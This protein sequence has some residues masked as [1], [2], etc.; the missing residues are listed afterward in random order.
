MPFIAIDPAT[1][2]TIAEYP[3]LDRAAAMR[4]V[5]E[6]DAAFRA[7][8]ATDF[9][10]RAVPMRHA[11]RLLRERAN[12]LAELMAREMGK[13][14]GDGRAEVEKCAW[15]CEYYADNAAAFLQDEPAPTDATDSYVTYRPLGPVL[16]VMPWNFPLWQVFRFVAP[17]LMAG[18]AGLLKHAP[19]VPGC[20]LAI[21][22]L[23]RDAGFPEHLFRN[24]FIENDLVGEVIDDPRVRAVT[25]TGSTRAGR[26]VAARAG[27]A[28]K[29]TVL[30]LGGSDPYI[31]LADADLELA[32]TTCVTSRMINGGQSCIS[33]KRFIVARSVAE[34]FKRLVVTAMEAL[35]TGDPFDEATDYGPMARI[36]LRDEL[37]RQVEASVAAGARVLTGAA[38][39]RTPGAFYPPTV[40]ADVA[41][42][43]PAYH[44]ELFGPVAAIITAEDETDALR[45][46]NDSD[47]GLGAAVFTADAARGEDLAARHLE[48]G[49]CFVNS[50]VK[51]D[52]RLPFGGIKN[53][54]Y[55]RELSSHGI[56][57][58]VN[59]KAVFR[60]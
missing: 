36:D 37:H 10:A 32:A 19:N 14:P 9:A 24:L 15:V 38:I 29:K 56:R 7:W 8:R 30:E 52:P 3:V 60:K 13:P 49:A 46:A 45:I 26:A 41:P 20:A 12:V 1:G 40:L 11:A 48:A 27:A 42:G 50:F 28:L 43:M 44:E 23:L 47:Y 22:T 51:S 53:S 4:V 58:F 54:G 57:E 16:A 17:A 25:L 5:T 59:V 33:A 35:R 2:A 39:P 31:V 21:E 55:G 6:V 34:E 18:N